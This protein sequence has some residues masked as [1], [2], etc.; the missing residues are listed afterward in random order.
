M[1]ASAATRQ[2]LLGTATG[3]ALALVAFAGADHPPPPGF[4]VVVIAIALWAVAI[5]LCRWKVRALPRPRQL[6]TIALL[7]SVLG[8]GAF[9]LAVLQSVVIQ[10]MPGSWW[11]LVGFAVAV[12]VSAICALA[13]TLVSWFF[14]DR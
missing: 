1:K 14:V 13:V 4:L 2:V 3:T 12:L 8:A 11:L 7:G 5:S 6:G 10:G 9:V